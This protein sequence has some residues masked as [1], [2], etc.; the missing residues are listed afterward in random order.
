MTVWYLCSNIFIERT[1]YDNTPTLHLISELTLSINGTIE[2][3]TRAY[4]EINP[5]ITIWNGYKLNTK[6]IVQTNLT[7]DECKHSTGYAAI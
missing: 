3:A 7:F 4:L 2:S 5:C 6:L 1:T